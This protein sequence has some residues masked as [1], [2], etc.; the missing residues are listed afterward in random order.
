MPGS[1]LLGVDIGTS[2][3]KGVLCTPDGSLLATAVIEHETS[4][5]R[6]GWAEHDADALWWAEFVAVTRELTSGRWSGS[7]VGA[8]AVSGMGPCV[9]PVDAAGHPLRPAILYGIDTRATA[10][11]AW[12]NERFGEREMLSIGG[13]ALSAQSLGPKVLW[14]RRHEPDLFARMTM[15]HT[16]S[17]YVIH[18]LTG[19]HVMDLRS[20]SYYAPLFDI[21]RLAWSDRFAE[22]IIG[23]DKLP[24]LGN[25]SEVAGTIRQAASTETGLPVGTPVT[26]GTTDGGAEAVSAGVQRPGDTM[27]MYGST[28]VFHCVVTS[29]RRDSRMWTTVY[30]LPGLL[31]AGGGLATAGLLTQ[32]AVDTLS[33]DAARNEAFARLIAAASALP[34]GADGLLCLPYFAGERTPLQDPHARGLLAGLTLRHTPAHL[35]R[36]ALEGIGFAA[37]HNLDVMTAMGAA[38][39]RLV[40]VGGGTRNPLWLQI[41]SDVTGLPQ[42]VPARTIG[43]SLGDAF[44]AGLG[45]G[46]V[47]SLDALDRDWVT[48]ERVIEPEAAHRERYKALYPLFRSL[49][50][51][52]KASVHQ[53]G[54]IVTDGIP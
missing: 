1:L 8:V 26:F 32:W 39:E 17:G 3:T 20:A 28:M 54:R 49:Y 33:A 40:A 53:L 9:L 48:I 21:E 23:L 14:L 31:A 44:L 35:F 34:A 12:L 47:P 15:I 51:E 16:T 42:E 45:S 43:A 37:R 41:V 38:P 2:S 13:I 7:D 36:A 18:R 10:E 6:P 24:R 30:P 52:T 19:E 5:P 50:E 22:P 27:V 4:F 11:I 25:A 29:A 46:I